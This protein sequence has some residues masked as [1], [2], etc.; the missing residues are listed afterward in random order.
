M[1]QV[2]IHFE[3]ARIFLE[4]SPSYRQPNLNPDEF[5]KVDANGAVLRGETGRRR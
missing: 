2:V 3:R 5:V 4:P 1:R